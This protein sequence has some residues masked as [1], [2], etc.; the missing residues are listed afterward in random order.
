[1]KRALLVALASGSM[2]MGP[3]RATRIGALAEADA[4][5]DGAAAVRCP[6]PALCSDLIDEYAQALVR[7]QGCTGGDDLACGLRAPRTLRCPGCEL[8]VSDRQELDRLRA[9][10]DAAGCAD[11]PLR[12]LTADGRCPTGPCAM[13]LTAPRCAASIA[14]GSAGGPDGGSPTGQCQDAEPQPCPPAVITGAPCAPYDVCIGGGQIA[15]TCFAP[16]RTWTCR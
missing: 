3:C 6:V 12:G 13:T 4:G 11:C 15:C 1:V 16:D 2:G 9:T 5:P 10:F 14:P 8:W 7:A